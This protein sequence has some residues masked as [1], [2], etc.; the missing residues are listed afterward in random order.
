MPL[1]AELRPPLSVALARPVPTIPTPD[2]MPGSTRYEPKWDG[3][4][5]L[6]VVDDD[7]SLWSRQ[8]KNLTR[9]FPELAAA[10]R[11]QLP[12]GVIVDGEAVIW[13]NDRLDFNA[14]LQR[15]NTTTLARIAHERPASYAAFDLL[16]VADRDTR[17]LPFDD[18]RTLLTELATTWS[19]PLNLSPITTDPDTATLW[20]ESL[21]SSGIEGIMAK[22]GSQPYKGG[23]RA[24][25]KIK[26]RDTLDVICAA[27]TGPLH[28][29]TNLVLGLPVSG[30]LRIVGRTTALPSETART[31]GKLLRSPQGPHP[32]PASV[33]SGAISRFNRGSGQ[34]VELTRVEP[35]VVEISADVAR[36]GE[37]FR[38][39]VRYLRARP[40]IPVAEV[41]ELMSAR[42][43]SE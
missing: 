37:S 34:R 26:H 11:D 9:S 30:E 42:G 33:K 21:T 29:P 13:N 3:F 10:A 7:V 25:V 41:E 31:L 24:W 1:P 19:P 39:A 27:V 12:H 40:E 6:I 23:E 28:H 43:A 38:H 2:A 4:R 35:L 14:L 17:P 16:A 18:R 32:W 36:S 8:G 20:F 15:L 22:G 5:L